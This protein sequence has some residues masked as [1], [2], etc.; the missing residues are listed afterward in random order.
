MSWTQ[1]VLQLVVQKFW[2]GSMAIVQDF[3][4]ICVNWKI[5]A[6]EILGVEIEDFKESFCMQSRI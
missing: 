1:H 4:L 2:E 3:Q 6:E 5:K